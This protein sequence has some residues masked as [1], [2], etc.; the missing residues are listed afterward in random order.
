ML[1][2]RHTDSDRVELECRSFVS[3][4]R[5]LSTARLEAAR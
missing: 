2:A 3:Q 1:K 5:A 4:A